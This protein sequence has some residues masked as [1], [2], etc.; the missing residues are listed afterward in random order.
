MADSTNRTGDSERKLIEFMPYDEYYSHQLYTISFKMNLIGLIV[1]AAFI[2]HSFVITQGK[3]FSNGY[4]HG[5][6]AGGFFIFLMALLS[7]MKNLKQLRIV[8]IIICGN[9]SVFL[10]VSVNIYTDFVLTNIIHIIVFFMFGAII[11]APL[12]SVRLFILPNLILNLL[13]I[14]SMIYL[15]IEYLQVIKFMMFSLTA[16]V[17]VAF[18]VKYLK[19]GAVRLYDSAVQNY[20]L[21]NLDALSKLLNRRSWYHQS[22]EKCRRLAEKPEN[23]AFIMLDIDHFKNINDTFGHDCGDIVIQRVASCLLQETREGDIVGRLGGEKFGLL[24]R[25]SSL[26]EAKQIAE[27]IRIAISTLDITYNQNNIPVTAS[28]GLV[29]Y[30]GV[31]LESLVKKGDECMYMAKKNGRKQ[32]CF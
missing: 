21:S 25:V 16:T 15:K 4:L 12:L 9:I 22:E 27:R 29:Q 17:F 8:L 14:A 28:L 26:N 32:S 5:Y 30:D 10:L 23:L 18:I 11:V 7:I 24:L 13:I 1:L 20:M 31:S 2:V 6:I 3:S 19:E